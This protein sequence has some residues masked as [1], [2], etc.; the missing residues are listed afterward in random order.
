VVRR[1]GQSYFIV[2]VELF[3]HLH[4]VENPLLE[5]VRHA[6]LHCR[7]EARYREGTYDTGNILKHTE[8]SIHPAWQVICIGWVGV[9]IDQL[10]I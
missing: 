1:H 8:S 2:H 9:V 7:E 6:D 5:V 4:E 3:V 10:S